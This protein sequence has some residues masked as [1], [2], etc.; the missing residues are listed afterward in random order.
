MPVPL[1]CW[2]NNFVCKIINGIIY[3][4]HFIFPSFVLFPCILPSQ[5]VHES[6]TWNAHSKVG[7]LDNKDHKPGG[8]N[9]HVRTVCLSVCLCHLLTT[10][11]VC[12]KSNYFVCTQ[13]FSGFGCFL[14]LSFCLFCCELIVLI[15]FLV[16]FKT[17]ITVYLY[18][19]VFVSPWSMVSGCYLTSLTTGGVNADDSVCELVL[20]FIYRQA[21]NPPS[22]PPKKK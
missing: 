20:F 19:H 21:I 1:T 7:S 18:C 22:P 12:S 3:Y 4:F 17:S 9:I 11:S 2:N 16:E 15:L 6:V 8:G 5:I 10:H 14:Y 13:V